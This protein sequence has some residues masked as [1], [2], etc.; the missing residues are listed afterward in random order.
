MTAPGRTAACLYRKRKL[1]R[2]RGPPTHAPETTVVLTPLSAA[3]ANGYD[4]PSHELWAQ[5]GVSSVIRNPKPPAL[6]KLWPRKRFHYC[7]RHRPARK[8]SHR[9]K[10]I[11]LMCTLFFILF[12]RGELFPT[13]IYRAHLTRQ[14][15]LHLSQVCF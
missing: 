7:A 9:E 5:R 15:I 10:V 6:S 13:S 3:E 4:I 8:S 14:I 12:Q 1:R 2:I 11:N